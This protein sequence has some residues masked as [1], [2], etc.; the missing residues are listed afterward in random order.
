MKEELSERD[1]IDQ[2]FALLPPALS[3]SIRKAELRGGKLFVSL[4]SATA[5]HELY[6]QKEEL[7]RRM[8]GDSDASVIEEIVLI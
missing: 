8:K 7:L 1:L 5:R 6:Y 3:R 4:S 2:F